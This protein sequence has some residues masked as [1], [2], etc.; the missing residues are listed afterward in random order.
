L[1][2]FFWP[3]TVGKIPT[4]M[5]SW[6]F[7]IVAITTYL[8]DMAYGLW[9]FLYPM[10]ACLKLIHKFCILYLGVPGIWNALEHQ[11]SSLASWF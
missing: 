7:G 10:G 11:P 3:E 9:L 6:K 4:A 5:A 2:F 1:Y 8:W